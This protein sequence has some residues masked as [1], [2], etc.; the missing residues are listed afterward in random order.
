[1]ARDA[2]G[3]LLRNSETIAKLKQLPGQPGQPSP[4]LV[5][6]STLLETTKLNEVESLELVRP[7]IAQGR[8]NFVENWIKEGK[9][10][11]SSELGDLIQPHNSTLALSV[12]QSS[13]NNEK[14]IQGMVETKQFAQIIPYCQKTGFKP[15]F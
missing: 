1:M 5:Y 15:N 4:V 13:G 9:L 14:V 6:F 2:P 11:F 7:V 8:M 3:K 12:Y 10:T